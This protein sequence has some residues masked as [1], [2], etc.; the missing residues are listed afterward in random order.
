MRHSLASLLLVLF[1]AA[2][3]QKGDLYHPPAEEAEE[4]TP[5]ENEDRDGEAEGDRP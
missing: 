1:L 3:G 5:E 4:D 2:C